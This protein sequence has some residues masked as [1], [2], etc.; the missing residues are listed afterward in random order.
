[1]K[2]FLPVVPA[3][4]LA[5]TLGFSG[6]QEG[7][8]Y[9]AA[10]QYGVRTDPLMVDAQVGDL[11]EDVYDPDRPGVMP[12]MR[13]ED[14]TSPDN[15]L[16][17][18][19]MSLFTRETPVL[20]DPTVVAQDDRKKLDDALTELF[21][22]PAEPKVGGIDDATRKALELDDASVQKGRHYYR[23][24][25]VHCHGVAGDGRGP[26]ARWINPHPR[27]FRQGLF[28]FMSVDQARGQTDLPP[29]REDLLY[30]L[31]H[32]I[33]ATA[34]PSF[35][36]LGN[37]DLNYLVSYVIHLSM[38]GK[39]EF[40]TLAKSFE[41]KYANGTFTAKFADD[42]PI[43]DSLKDWHKRNAVKWLASQDPKNWIQIPPYDEHFVNKNVV[44]SGEGEWQVWQTLKDDEAKKALIRGAIA[45]ALFNKDE[46]RLPEAKKILDLRGDQPDKANCKQ[47][48]I[49]YG[50]QAKFKFDSWATLTR[51]NNFTNGVFRGGRR[52][53]D[54]YHRVHS[55]ING[56][57]MT[58]F[59]SVLSSNSIWDLANFVQSLS[60]PSM[61]RSMGVVID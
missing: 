15:P 34:M 41:W 17:T 61:R 8:E 36:L 16:S 1:M 57:N 10:V 24:H 37:K 58:P 50:R 51:P 29:R 18:K 12:I 33:E 47:C 32:G 56:A 39:A 2:R 20:I 13:R 14:V 9:S 52:P 22:T 4:L 21:G 30:T 43:A 6:C 19:G 38:R 11:G 27:D 25:C 31:R 54:I 23:I 26:T 46:P 28:K 45:E 3:G 5:L 42:N 55:G 7:G 44:K 59:G 60:Y 53:I 49:D 35:V 48:H 40:D